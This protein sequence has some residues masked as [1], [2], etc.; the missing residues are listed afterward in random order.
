MRRVLGLDQSKDRAAR[1]RL[2]QGR[3]E[4]WIVPT[5]G[6]A[7]A[8][9]VDNGYNGRT[10]DQNVQDAELAETKREV[11]QALHILNAE[12]LCEWS[13][14]HISRRLPGS[15]HIVITGHLHDRGMTISDMSID[16][17]AIIDLDGDLID[18]P[19]GAPGERFIHTEIY[20]L[21]PDVGSV[22]HCHPKYSIAW[23]VSGR[24]LLPIYQQT[25]MFAPQVPVLAYPGQIDTPELGRRSAEAIGNSRALLLKGHGA[26][27]IGS[28][29]KEAFV[30]AI[31]LEKAAE[32]QYIVAQ[33]GG[34]VEGIDPQFTE[35]GFMKGISEER[36]FEFV[37]NHYYRS[38]SQSPA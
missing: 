25:T 2:S 1:L 32:M 38:Y 13:T 8:R 7:K 19:V 24:P 15:D 4:R 34:R 18:G 17:A 16:D 33:I 29:V 20:R 12:G 10:G 9:Y 3:V 27:T 22:V 11:V 37:W 6:C 36:Y 35:N 14:G 5:G 26:V 31:A 23:S 28:T 30:T 21:R